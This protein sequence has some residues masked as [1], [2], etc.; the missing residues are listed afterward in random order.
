[1]RLNEA[2]PHWLA[3]MICKFNIVQYYVVVD[4]LQGR[5]ACADMCKDT[6]DGSWQIVAAYHIST[7]PPSWLHMTIFWQFLAFVAGV[8]AVYIQKVINASGDQVPQHL[9]NITSAE[10]LKQLFFSSIFTPSHLVIS[11]RPFS[12]SIVYLALSSHLLNGSNSPYRLW[13][14]AGYLLHWRRHA[15]LR[16]RY[17][18]LYS[19]HGPK[20]V[21]RPDKMDEVMPGLYILSTTENV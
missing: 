19:H 8:L 13:I 9:S 14:T 11:V 6:Y 17:A 1:M 5:T 20:V 7:V 2:D 3:Q 18:S 21:S 15:L 16:C 10:D 4:Y 12:F